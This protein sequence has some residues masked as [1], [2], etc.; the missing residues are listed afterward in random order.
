MSSATNPYN[1]DQVMNVIRTIYGSEYNTGDLINNILNPSN[2]LQSRYDIVE[3]NE[4][5][6]VYI[7]LPGVLKDNITVEFKSTVLKLSFVRNKPYDH[8]VIKNEIYYGNF[9]KN[10]QLPISITNKNSVKLTH[11]NGVLV[12]RV[13]KNTETS[14]G[15][16]MVVD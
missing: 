5:L 15:F 10:I 8:Q 6:L 7:D 11:K 14:Q 1:L 4:E 9:E 12:V 13:D 16:S 2:C 3:N